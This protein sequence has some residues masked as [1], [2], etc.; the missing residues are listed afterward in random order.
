M[1][2]NEIQTIL[3][4]LGGKVSILA[5]ENRICKNRDVAGRQLINLL[6]KYINEEDWNKIYN[7]IDDIFIKE[8][9]NEWHPKIFLDDIK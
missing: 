8:L 6:S 1:N 4:N 9:M 7:D 5:E 3:E 2:E